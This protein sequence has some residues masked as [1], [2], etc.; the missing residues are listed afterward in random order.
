MTVN[1]ASLTRSLRK[2][3]GLTYQ[4]AAL[5]VDILVEAVAEGVAKS[6]RVELRGL[7][8][9]SVVRIG[10]KNFPASVSENKTVPAHGRVL[11]R[12]SEKLRRAVWNREAP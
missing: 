9:F 1:R 4:E 12:P 2:A 8:S 6:G 11:F 10:K 7:G 5:C 3:A